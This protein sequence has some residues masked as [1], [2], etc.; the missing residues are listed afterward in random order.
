MENTLRLIKENK[1]VAIL[2]GV[3]SDKILKTVEALY[4]GGI[5]LV[6]ITFDQSSETGNVDTFNA[7]KSVSEAFGDRLSIGAGTV[8]TVEQTDLAVEAGARYIISPNFDRDVVERTLELGAVSMPGV[9]TP[10]EITNAYKAGAHFVKVFPSG[11][12]G[13]SYIKAISAPISHIPLLVVGGINLDNIRSF[14]DAG[15]AGFGIGTSIVNKTLI[16]EGRFD[17]LTELAE[18]YVSVVKGE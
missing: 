13:L 8:M 4:K 5:R 9:L 18:K 7:I 11:N 16:N 15:V 1:I 2:R 14:L 6:E 17:E 10:T 3:D 12:F